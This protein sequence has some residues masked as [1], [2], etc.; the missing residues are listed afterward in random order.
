MDIRK[1]VNDLAF[2][3][4][5]D[6]ATDSSAFARI[7]RTMKAGGEF[8]RAAAS[9]I[10]TDLRRRSVN[11]RKR[12][13]SLPGG[14]RAAIL[15]CLFGGAGQIRLGQTAKGSLI[16]VM[17]LAGLAAYMILGVVIIGLGMYDAW[18][19]GKRFQNT[20]Q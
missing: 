9:T 7:S 12:A 6:T 16:I 3:L 11:A 2:E 15:S 5:A 8:S 4:K 10:G 20:G 17:S 14:S 13:E 18:V 19:L 1:L